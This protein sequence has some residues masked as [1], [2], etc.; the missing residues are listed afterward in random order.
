[1][2]RESRRLSALAALSQVILGVLATGLSSNSY[3]IV[4][5][6]TEHLHCYGS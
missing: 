5:R 4:P 1:M 3:P 6:M 2:A